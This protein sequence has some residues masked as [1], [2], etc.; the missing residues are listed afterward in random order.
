MVIYFIDTKN[1][2]FLDILLVLVY[3]M[4]FFLINYL[5]IIVKYLRLISKFWV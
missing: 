3:V 5:L 1:R 2:K 4:C